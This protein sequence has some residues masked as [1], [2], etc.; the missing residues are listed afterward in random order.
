MPDRAVCGRVTLRTIPAAPR[1]PVR[2]GDEG[3]LV[4]ARCGERA[5][6]GT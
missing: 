3:T 4:R 2:I 5:P 1:R 6:S